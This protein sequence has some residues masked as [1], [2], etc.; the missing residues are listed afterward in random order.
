MTSKWLSA[1]AIASFVAH[2]SIEPDKEWQ[3]EIERA[4][5]SMEAM[6]VLVTDDFHQS[7]WT[8]QEIGFAL[9]RKIPVVSVL[10]GASS[11]LGFIQHRQAIKLKLESVDNCIKSIVKAMAIRLPDPMRDALVSRFVEAPS[12]AEAQARF[13][14]LVAIEG[15]DIRH[16]STIIEEF[17]K[18]SQLHDCFYLTRGNRLL[19]FLSSCTG[20]SYQF[21][22]NTIIGA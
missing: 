2:D 16:A 4:L 9:G 3:K 10:F 21:K 5:E 20:D 8:N 15:Y 1:F 19:D 12:Y 6:L 22:G 18:N 11:P 13:D 7:V 14:R 17:S